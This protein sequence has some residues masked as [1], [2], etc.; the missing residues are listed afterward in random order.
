M[1]AME[2]QRALDL[3]SLE[4]VHGERWP[5]F[6]PVGARGGKR[7]QVRHCLGVSCSPCR[8][9]GQCSAEWPRRVRPSLVGHILPDPVDDDLYRRRDLSPIVRSATCSDYLTWIGTQSPGCDG[10]GE[11]W[12]RPPAQRHGGPC[13][14]RL[15][16]HVGRGHRRDTRSRTATANPNTANA[17]TSTTTPHAIISMFPPHRPPGHF[18]LTSF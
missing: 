14:S 13:R 1:H 7:L 16:Y 2:L 3:P 18:A 8:I 6:M 4:F 9:A 5:H 10:R 12:P 17:P 15:T 11:W